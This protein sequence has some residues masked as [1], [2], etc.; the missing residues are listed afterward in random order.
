MLSQLFKT[1][2]RVDEDDQEQYAYDESANEKP[3]AA[4][5]P[6]QYHLS[7][8]QNYSAGE[9]SQYHYVSK[10]ELPPLHHDQMATSEILSKT[11]LHDRIRGLSSGFYRAVVTDGRLHFVSS[12]SEDTRTARDRNANSPVGERA[13]ISAPQSDDCVTARD[14]DVEVE[15]KVVT[16][17][18]VMAF[19]KM[20]GAKKAFEEYKRQRAMKKMSNKLQEHLDIRTAL[21]DQS[22]KDVDTAISPSNSELENCNCRTGIEMVYGMESTTR[23]MNEKEVNSN[24][25]DES[26][27]AC[28]NKLNHEMSIN[29]NESCESDV[30]FIGESTRIEDDNNET[31]LN[32]SQE[33]IGLNSSFWLDEDTP[34]QQEQDQ[35]L[36]MEL[37]DVVVSNDQIQRPPYLSRISNLTQ[38]IQSGLQLGDQSQLQI[39]SNS[40]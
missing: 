38:I 19:F 7:E 17:Q 8:L 9:K 1:G 16:V 22:S 35:Q 12:G 20:P 6:S 2:P 14:F 32:A 33:S 11:Q 29:L 34:K 25:L 26:W 3:K 37:D 28:R 24:V 15:E 31:L 23:R 21:D 30:V 27:I 40:C 36:T 5:K 13:A 4:A 10:E 39:E 18:D